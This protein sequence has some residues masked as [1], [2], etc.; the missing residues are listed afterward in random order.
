[1]YQIQT[2]GTALYA[3]RLAVA[4]GYATLVSAIVTFAAC[5]SCLTFLNRLGLKNF[6]NTKWYRSFYK[7]HGYAWPIFLF[8]LVL[9]LLTSLM[10]TE[11]PT[12]GDPDATI[13]WVVLSFAFGSFFFVGTVLF[14]CR[15]LVS[16][17]NLF[18][19]KNL[20]SN[21]MYLP[22]YKYHSFYWMVLILFIVGHFISAYIHIGLWPG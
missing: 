15:S 10:H 2:V 13:H 3:E 20:I 19:G 18:S 6:A 14:S 8:F 16:A 4:L 1:M 11:I 5:R 9:H 17:I 21:K 7:Y 12:A 22:F